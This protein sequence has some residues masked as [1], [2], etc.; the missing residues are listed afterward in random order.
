MENSEAITL[1]IGPAKQPSWT[2]LGSLAWGETDPETGIIVIYK[3]GGVPWFAMNMR[4]GKTVRIV[5]EAP[6]PQPEPTHADWVA[7]LHSFADKAK[8]FSLCYFI[9]AAEGPIKIGHSVNVRDRMKAMQ[10][11][12]PVM[13]SVLATAPGGEERETAYHTQFQDSR[14]HGEWFE[15]TPELLAEIERLSA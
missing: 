3:K 12:C 15:R 9:G 1:P 5:R 7:M 14:L 13:L 4:T 2:S 8:T 6:E 10:A 11:G